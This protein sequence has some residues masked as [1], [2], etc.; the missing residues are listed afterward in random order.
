M[1]RTEGA[2]NLQAPRDLG[3]ADASTMQLP[4]LVGVETCGGGPAQP[5][6]VLPCMRQAGAH[7]FP[8]NFSFELREY[9]QPVARPWYGRQSRRCPRDATQETHYRILL[10]TRCFGLG[11]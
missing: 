7:T 1:R 2:A 4:Y 8:Q 3:F 9:C 6:T 11:R 10:C 5:L